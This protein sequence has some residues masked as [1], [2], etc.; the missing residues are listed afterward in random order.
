MVDVGMSREE[1]SHRRNKVTNEEGNKRDGEIWV[2][3][4]ESR[5]DNMSELQ[6]IVTELRASQKWVKENKEHILNA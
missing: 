6:Q 1:E 5:N 4:N 2:N 3:I